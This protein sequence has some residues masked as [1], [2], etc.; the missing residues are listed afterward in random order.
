MNET[1]YNVKLLKVPRLSGIPFVLFCQV[2]ESSILGPLILPKLLQDSGFDIIMNTEVT[3]G[4]TF[5]PIPNSSFSNYYN[6]MKSIEDD[7]RNKDIIN[8]IQEITKYQDNEQQSLST[9]P[10]S[11][12]YHKAYKSNKLDPLTIAKKFLK[13]AKEQKEMTINCIEVIDEELLLQQASVSSERYSKGQFI[14]VLDGVLIGVKDEMDVK[15][16]PTT[17]GTD[18]PHFQNKKLGIDSAI[19]RKLRQMGAIIACK[20]RMAEIGITPRSVHPTKMVRNPFDLNHEVGGSSSGSGA[21]VS[22]GLFPIALGADGG[23]SIRMFYLFIFPVSY[24][25]LINSLSFLSFD[26]VLLLCVEFMD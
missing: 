12:D 10:N 19:V 13:F 15:G 16:M 14:S 11:L 6:C 20:L 23:G 7:I 2:A 5:F 3:E 24:L 22:C 26:I 4:P 8:Y 1:K 18:M 17:L 25:D 9:F 21:A